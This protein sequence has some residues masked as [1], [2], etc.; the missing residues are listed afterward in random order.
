M[1]VAAKRNIFM[2]ARSYLHL[3]QLHRTFFLF[4]VDEGIMGC[5]IL[6][7]NIWG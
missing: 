2:H 7:N 4:K 5:Q 3:D 1:T 6:L